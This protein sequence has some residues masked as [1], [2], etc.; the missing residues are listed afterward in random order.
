MALITWNDSMSVNVE[1]ID[2]Q[3]QKLVQIIND[4]HD[5]MREG[6]EKEVLGNVLTR[7]I[8]YTSY[9]FSTEEKYF[10]K[11][12]YPDSDPHKKEHRELLE[13]VLEFKKEF[14]EG[15]VLLTIELMNFLKNWL[16]NHMQGSDKKYGLFFNEKGLK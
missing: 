9:H 6:K 11:F 2:K 12:G 15:K 5:A 4:L 7:L 14:D 1:E 13:Q 10:D 16:T 3:H 8:D